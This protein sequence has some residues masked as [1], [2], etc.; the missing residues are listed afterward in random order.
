MSR[1]LCIALVLF[2]LCNLGY[3][4]SLGPISI[5]LGGSDVWTVSN[6]TTSYIAEV[7]GTVHTDLM[8][9]GVVP[10]MYWRDNDVVYRYN[11]ETV[12][13][14]AFLLFQGGLLLMNGPT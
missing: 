6:S 7:P 1:A 10:D 3:S 14:F 5:D 12:K 8:A 13:L 11:S 2:V 4:S 9:A